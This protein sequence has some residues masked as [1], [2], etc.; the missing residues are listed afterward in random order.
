MKTND[1][2]HIWQP[3]RIFDNHIPAIILR[4]LKEDLFPFALQHLL[5]LYSS[6]ATNNMPNKKKKSSKQHRSSGS[7]TSNQPP[8]SQATYTG[9]ASGPSTATAAPTNT[10]TITYKCLRLP[11]DGSPIERL[12]Y[13]TTS[14]IPKGPD[15]YFDVAADLRRYW[16]GDYL[17]R[18]TQSFCVGENPLPALNGQYILYYS[19]DSSQPANKT[20]LSL[21][22]LQEAIEKS[23]KNGEKFEERMFYHGDMFVVRLRDWEENTNFR[24]K[25]D[26]ISPQLVQPLI[27]LL[28]KGLFAHGWGEKFLEYQHK[29]NEDTAKC[30]EKHE[31]H[32]VEMMSRL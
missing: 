4:V 8:H 19:T 26:D 30:M 20:L 7:R 10:N 13:T 22:V 5:S 21:P 9:S 2:M 14:S 27:Q 18:Q 29:L 16:H 17:A 15:S 23:T 1:E 32:R 24:S 12:D 25:H 6:L 28:D 31:F 11:A 3:V